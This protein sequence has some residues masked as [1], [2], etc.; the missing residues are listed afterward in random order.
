M[1]FFLKKGIICMMPFDLM[2]TVEGYWDYKLRNQSL[3][4]AAEGNHTKPPLTRH[5]LKKYQKL[6]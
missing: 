6:L 1:S 5:D 3:D 4:L 2:I